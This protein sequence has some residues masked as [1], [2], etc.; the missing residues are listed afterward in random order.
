MPGID[1]QKA[2]YRQETIAAFENTTTV[3]RDTVTTEFESDGGSQVT[4]L[5]AGSGGATA[6]TRGTNGDIPSRLDDNAQHLCQMTEWHDKVKK[7][8]FNIFASQGNQRALMQR[9]SM[10]VMNRKIDQDIIAALETGT[11]SLAVTTG[12]LM[13]I[14]RQKVIL[15]NN[16]VDTSSN[17]TGLITPAYFAYM[18]SI[19]EFSNSDYSKLNPADKGSETFRWLN[20][21]W[22][23][24]NNLPGNGTAAEK[25]FMYHNEAIGHAADAQALNTAIGYNEENDYSYVRSTMFMGSKLL[26]NEGVMVSIHDGTAFSE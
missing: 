23:V 13:H 15:M 1:A 7:T 4:F 18:M 19:P 2:R 25:V 11:Q 20:I 16:K 26:Q 10:G 8:R 5:V 3:L 21:N 22:I 6:V 12:S 17:I 9:T 24:H 14:L